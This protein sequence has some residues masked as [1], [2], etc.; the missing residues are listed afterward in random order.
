MEHVLP[1]NPKANSVWVQWFPTEDIREKYTHHLSNLLLLP[2]RKNSE[3]QNYDFDE[4]KKKYFS[5]AKGVSTFA[6]TSQVLNEKDWTPA[7][8]DTR[9]TNLLSALKTLWEL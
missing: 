9:Q 8:L 1:Q 6:L 5:S 4:K 2:R 3:A 7:L